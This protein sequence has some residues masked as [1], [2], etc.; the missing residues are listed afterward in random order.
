MRVDSDPHW[1]VLGQPFVRLAGF[2]PGRHRVEFGASLDG[3]T[4]SV[5]PAVVTFR[6]QQAWY[7]RGWFLT[8]VA[9]SL[10]GVVY[11]IYRARVAHLLRLERQR[12]R[13]AMD[14]HDDLGAGL[15]SAGLLVGLLGEADLDPG[16]RERLV[17]RA[18]RL[19]RDLGSS[20]TDIVWSL[21]PGSDTLAELVLFLR[22]RAGDMFPQDGATRV[23]IVAPDPCPPVHL[24]LPLRRNLQWIT[25]EAMH[26]A[27]RHAGARRVVVALE[28]DGDEWLL[29][30]RDD[31]C[32]FAAAENGDGG[33]GLGQ[34]SMRR[35]AREIG[36]RLEVRSS[37]GEGTTVE[38]RFRTRGR[39]S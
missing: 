39:R 18:G 29:S 4:W 26:N 21:R 28:R 25:V 24:D 16:E 22:Q 30:V 27:A 3:R 8:L 1:T 17:V 12:T 9:V 35:R 7:L 13:I 23:E 37:P 15:G 20:L 5:S 31:G 19:L 36:A 38:L 11:G 14:L 32:G 10:A 34:Q 6:V 33:H 2:A